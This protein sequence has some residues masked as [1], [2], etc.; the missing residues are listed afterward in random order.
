M[1][2]S[3]PFVSLTALFFWWFKIIDRACSGYVVGTA[4]RRFPRMHLA[5][6]TRVFIVERCGLVR[7]PFPT[8]DDHDGMNDDVYEISDLIGTRVR[9]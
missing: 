8:I 4:S 6:M 9:E 3:V 1:R 2:V 7:D 5:Y